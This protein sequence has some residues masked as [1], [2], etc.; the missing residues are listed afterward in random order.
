M[1]DHYGRR[2]QEQER[3]EQEQQVQEKKS[4]V[5]CYLTFENCHLDLLVPSRHHRHEVGGICR[6]RLDLNLNSQ[7][8]NNK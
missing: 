2:N 8:S 3:K 4:L 1:S 7:M 6:L 5:I